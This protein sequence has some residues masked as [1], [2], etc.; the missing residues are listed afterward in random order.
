MY[1]RPSPGLIVGHCVGESMVHNVFVKLLDT[2]S[3]EDVITHPRHQAA[4][5][6]VA[7]LIAQLRAC[8][9][10]R[11]GYEFQ[12]DL[13]KLRL[14]VET[15]RGGFQQAV[16]RMRAGKQP[17]VGAPVPQSGQ[18]TNRIDAWQLEVEVC[19]RVIRQLK[20]VGD[21]LAWRVF[22][23]DRRHIFALC[24]NQSPGLMAG[25]EGL[26]AERQRID[27]VWREDGQFAILHDLTNCLRIG[28]MTVFG[29]G[30]PKTIEIKTN[31]QNRA[32]RQNR[33][34]SAA[35]KAVRNF[36]PLPGDNPGERVHDLDVSFKTYLSLLATGMLQ[37]D[38]K[39]LFA[40]KVPGNR[41]LIVAD[42]YG[43]SRQGWTGDEFSDRLRRK[44]L[45]VMRRAGLGLKPGYIVSAT[46]LDSVATDPTRVPF[47]IYPLHP[48][49][50]AR[51]IGD[52]AFF[53]VVTD[54]PVLAES[55]CEAGLKAKWVRPP[56]TADLMAGEVVIELSA[57]TSSPL[58]GTVVAE[59]TRNLQMRRNALDKYLIELI[60]QDAWL[61]GLKYLLMGQSL[62]P[63]QPWPV[64]RDENQVWI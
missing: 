7:R 3:P 14:A 44:Q 8:A 48:E 62:M 31:S 38:R 12:N 13:M 18:E 4:Q 60:D 37:A 39:G 34:I 32:R 49:A 33:R 63:R 57:K 40:A 20:C 50:C 21:A 17:Q 25:K 6:S 45:T 28:D 51:L 56:S 64:Y 29:D 54:G 16:K 11:D 47:A 24:R 27:Q 5:T 43:Y 58:R 1:L 22:A 2:E 41:A 35:H 55:L 19:N 10:V 23:F 15:D 53:T 61:E 52:L 26:E 46:S 59:V 42:I 9:N 30:E 36:G